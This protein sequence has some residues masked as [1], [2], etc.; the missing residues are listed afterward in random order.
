[1]AILWTAE[2]D[3]WEGLLINVY[4]QVFFSSSPNYSWLIKWFI[5][6]HV[7]RLFDSF[8]SSFPAISGSAGCCLQNDQFIFIQE[9]ANSMSY[10]LFIEFCDYPISIYEYKCF[11]TPTRSTFRSSLA[12]Y[13]TSSPSSPSSAFNSLEC[14]AVC[15]LFTGSTN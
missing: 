14:I 3:N 7:W 5:W 12:A 8:R 13:S 4:R 10:Y 15:R 1:M 9:E 11:S 6:T 2:Q